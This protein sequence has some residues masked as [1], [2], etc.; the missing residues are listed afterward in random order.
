VIIR[1]EAVTMPTPIGE[2]DRN[3]IIFAFG[4]PCLLR[5][6]DEISA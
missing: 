4:A 2:S 3:A 6:L 1:I 5:K